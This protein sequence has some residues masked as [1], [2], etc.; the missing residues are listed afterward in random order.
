MRIYR[1][2][3]IHSIY[4]YICVSHLP[5]FSLSFLLIL[6]HFL[7]HS[8]KVACS[9]HHDSLLNFSVAVARNNIHQSTVLWNLFDN[10]ICQ[11][12]SHRLIYCPALCDAGL[13]QAGRFGSRWSLHK[14][15]L[16]VEM[17]FPAQLASVKQKL[18]RRPY[19]GSQA[20]DTLHVSMPLYYCTVVHICCCLTTATPVW[21]SNM[22]SFCIQFVYV[23]KKNTALIS[24]VWSVFSLCS[25]M[26]FSE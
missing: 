13:T 7:M 16:L 14:H 6:R 11:P 23:R 15:M 22:L 8:L 25:V 19:G 2:L 5:L 1:D 3:Y 9:I 26:E 4:T 20:R 17:V 24:D 21:V 12:V 18:F 10:S